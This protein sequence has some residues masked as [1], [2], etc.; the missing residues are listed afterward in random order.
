M[1]P[2][3]PCGGRAGCAGQK[4]GRKWLFLVVRSGTLWQHGVASRAAR[5]DELEPRGVGL[6]CVC[7]PVDTCLRGSSD[8]RFDPHSSP[9]CTHSGLASECQLVETSARRIV[10]LSHCRSVN[11][12][13]GLRAC[14]LPCVLRSLH[15]GL[16]GGL[17]QLSGRNLKPRKKLTF[18]PPSSPQ[19]RGHVEV[20]G[21]FVADS[22]EKEKKKH[23]ERKLIVCPP[24]HG[25]AVRFFEQCPQPSVS[26]WYMSLHACCVALLLVFAPPSVVGSFLM[27]LSCVLRNLPGSLGFGLYCWLVFGSAVGFWAC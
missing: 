27:F 13:K 20:L 23:G 9:M 24:S 12:S 15:G 22:L 3:R 19:P 18:H 16:Q 5:E 7:L 26:D 14:V 17:Y 25:L 11:V 8:R 4:S 21:G 1:G 2:N 6:P 10:E